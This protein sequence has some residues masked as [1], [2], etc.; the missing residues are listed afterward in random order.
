M[1]Y[2][3]EYGKIETSGGVILVIEREQGRPYEIGTREGHNR[4]IRDLIGT[5]RAYYKK[6]ILLD[7]TSGGLAGVSR[8]RRAI[9]KDFGFKPHAPTISGRPAFSSYW[10]ME[11]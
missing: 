4:Q 7:S 5:G 11:Y 6:V 8:G 9:I 10:V 1:P 3:I 2:E